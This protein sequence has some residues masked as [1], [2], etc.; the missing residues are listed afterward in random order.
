MGDFVNRAW[1]RV[2]AWITAT[3]IVGLN[4]KLVIDSIGGWLETS[5]EW[6]WV[7]LT[8]IVPVCGGLLAL[9]GW[10]VLQPWLA[11]RGERPRAIELPV[12]VDKF[13]A[14][15]YQR[16]LV[17][18][19][20]TDL[21]R[22]ALTHAVQMAKQHCSRLYLIHVEEDVTSQIYG[23]L[24]STREVEAG[25]DYLNRI[26]QSLQSESLEVETH[27]FHSPNPKEEIVRYA[28]QIR[29]DLLVM[30]AHGHQ[31]WKDLVFGD[32]INPV[33]HALNVPILV[34]RGER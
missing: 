31:R 21:D 20:H 34:V 4:I 13:A 17:P 15:P 26:A 22:V 33:R 1:V 10:V 16:I 18:L 23:S 9:L 24:A 28:R 27:I 29:P 32:T 14:C 2:L 8:L 30:G 25:R 19:D 7:I 12:S 3:I 5:G 6:R 11:R